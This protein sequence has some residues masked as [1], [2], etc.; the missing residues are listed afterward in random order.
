MLSG[1]GPKNHLKQVGIPVLRDLPVGEYLQDHPTVQIFTLIKNNSLVRTGGR[2]NVNQLYQ[3]LAQGSGPLSVL[4]PSILF[5]S[6][7]CIED[8]EWPNTY[9]YTIVEQISDLDQMVS[10][11]AA[12]REEW[13]QYF[14]PYLNRYVLLSSPHLTRVRSYGSVRLSSADPYAY[15]IIDPQ[16]VADGQDLKDLIEKIKFVLYLLT[17]TQIAEYVQLFPNAIPRCSY[18]PNP[19][20]IYECDQYIRCLLRETIKTGYHPVG[21]CRMGSAKRKDTVVD[22]NLRVKGVERLRV[23][24]ASVMPQIINAN[25]NAASIAIG[26]KGADL[27]KKDNYY[28]NY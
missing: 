25:T 6:T 3:L 15:P 17:E 11:M 13:K 9:T 2:L 5:Y 8:K 4:T 19:C 24:D 26:E 22:P 16:F 7:S 18:C 10:E 28:Y 23:C 27:I 21:T 20:P 12:N 14:K 1:I